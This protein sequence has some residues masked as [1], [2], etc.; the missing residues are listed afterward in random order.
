MD[1]RG[2]TQFARVNLV[3]CLATAEGDQPRVRGLLLWFADHTGFS[4]HRATS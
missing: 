2:C 4:V 1:L 3:C